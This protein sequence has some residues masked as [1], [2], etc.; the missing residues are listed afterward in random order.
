MLD[1]AIIQRVKLKTKQ[2]DDETMDKLIRCRR[3]GKND[4]EFGKSS[5]I[6]LFRSYHELNLIKQLVEKYF[7]ID[8]TRMSVQLV[9][10]ESFTLF[11][12][13]VFQTFK[14]INSNV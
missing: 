4:N 12:R 11:Y 8:S 3:R 13:S 10:T 6:A 1:L 2:T 5:V 7:K 9:F 14:G